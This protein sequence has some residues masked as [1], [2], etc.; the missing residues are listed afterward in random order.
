MMV[1]GIIVAALILLAFLRLGISAEYNE[2]GFRA[3]LS[4]AFFRKTIFDSEKPPKTAKKH[5]KTAEK[6]KKVEK[7]ST[8]N[9]PK[10]GSLD[11]LLD[12]LPDIIRILERSK[13]RILIKRMVLYFMPAGDDPFTTAMQFG[14]TSGGLGYVKAL[15]DSHFRVRKLDFRTAADFAATEP[16]IYVNAAL[17][18]AVWE[19]IYI[20]FA[21]FPIFTKTRGKTNEKPTDNQQ[22]GEKAHG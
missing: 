10:F 18:L 11:V 19:A 6:S 15:L 21:A 12:I 9:Q 22:K 3:R 14:Y 16:Y 2:S 4:V 7:K 13:R 17:S 5:K 8:K 1:V 20:I